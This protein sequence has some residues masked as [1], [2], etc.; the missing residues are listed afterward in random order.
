MQKI[1]INWKVY[2]ITNVIFLSRKVKKK[3]IVAIDGSFDATN[4]FTCRK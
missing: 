2:C 4:V 1:T 3:K